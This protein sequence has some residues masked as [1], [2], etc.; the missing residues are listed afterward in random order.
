[1]TQKLIEKIKNDH[2]IIHFTAKVFTFFLK[3][4]NINIQEKKALSISEFI[5]TEVE[6]SL[7]KLKIEEI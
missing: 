5:L 1:M 4:T 2:D 7:K 6:K 3:E